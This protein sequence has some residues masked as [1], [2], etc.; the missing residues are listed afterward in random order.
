MNTKDIHFDISPFPQTLSTL[1]LRDA[2]MHNTIS[3]WH[4]RVWQR[5]RCSSIPIVSPGK[6][7]FYVPSWGRVSPG[8]GLFT[9][10]TAGR[11]NAYL[12][13]RD[14]TG[15]EGGPYGSRGMSGKLRSDASDKRYHQRLL[16]RAAK[17]GRS[18][19]QTVTSSLPHLFSPSNSFELVTS[20]SVTR[21][22]RRWAEI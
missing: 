11:I 14:V 10:T 2:N 16:E 12:R 19:S 4:H 22:L 18:W 6:G 9:R 8:Q 3:V 21:S 17:L 15:D 1:P 5:S 13:K 7:S 20:A